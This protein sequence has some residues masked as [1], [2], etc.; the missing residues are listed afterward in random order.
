MQRY[1]FAEPAQF[2]LKNK[3]VQLVRLTES[4]TTCQDVRFLTII[5]ESNQF[6]NILSG[7]QNLS[8]IFFE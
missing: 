3:T 1:K 8:P 6:L 7:K 2:E 4:K 5:L